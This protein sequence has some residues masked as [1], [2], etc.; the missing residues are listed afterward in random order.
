MAKTL[1]RLLYRCSK[2][3]VRKPR[4]EFGKSKTSA[5]G[6]H[7]WCRECCRIDG[8]ARYAKLAP[9]AKARLL[10]KHR[11]RPRPPKEVEWNRALRRNYRMTLAEF[12]QRVLEQGGKCAACERSFT[13]RPQVDHDHSCCDFNVKT[14]GKCVRDLLCRSCNTALGRVND[15]PER[16]YALIT[17]L[18]KWN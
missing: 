11:N 13:T 7:Y 4:G 1:K 15:S 12:D 8:R 3:R 6:L 10:A 5:S 18:K 9:E 16:L 14:C 17:Y 2:C